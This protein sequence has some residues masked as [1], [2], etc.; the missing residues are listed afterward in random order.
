MA[1]LYLDRSGIELRPQ[2]RALGIFENDR[3]CRSVPLNLLERVVVAAP[4]SLSTGLI[5]WLARHGVSLVI[6]SRVEGRAACLMGGPLGDAKRRLAQYRAYCNPQWRRRWSVR[7]VRAKIAAQA[8]TLRRLLRA[9]SDQKQALAEALEQVLRL[10]REVNGA[11]TASLMGIEGAAAAAYFRGLATVFPPALGFQG[12][13]R[14]PP[15]DPVNACLSL[16]Y[17][18]A[19]WDAVQAV[20]AAGLDPHLG[21]YHEPAWNRESLACDLIEPLRPRLDEWVWE[22]FR[23]RTLRSEHFRTVRGACL[24]GKAGRR[25]FYEAHEALACRSRRRLRRLGQLLV[26]VLETEFGEKA[27]RETGSNEEPVS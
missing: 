26:R 10:G 6:L 3:Y 17:T 8:R 24:L 5:A 16:C 21:F 22:M 20:H 18:L 12:R 19:H 23:Q 27:V 11:E 7:L 13:N 14:R 9:R 15:R 1:T 25:I 4:T 2:G